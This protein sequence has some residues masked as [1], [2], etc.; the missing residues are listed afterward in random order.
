MGVSSAVVE[1][2][3]EIA[4]VAEPVEDDTFAKDS[5]SATLMNFL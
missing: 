3:A 4:G 1:F 5:A 2:S